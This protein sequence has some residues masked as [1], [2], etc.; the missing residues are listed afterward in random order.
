MT[1]ELVDSAAQVEPP[2]W[3]D[4][5]VTLRR[6]LH[7]HPELRFE[8]TRTASLLADRLQESGFSVSRG[9]AGTGVVATV[10]RGPGPHVVLRADLDALA[11]PD[12]KDVEYASQVAG[13]AHACGHDVHLT[14]MTTAAKR[15]MDAS[16][17]GRLTV[18]LQPAEEIPYGEP[19]GA[20]AVIDTGLLD[21]ASVDALLGVHCWPWLP[22]GTI[23]IDERVAMAAK[24]A[25][26]IEV[27]GVSAHAAT[28]T[29][30]RDALLAACNLVAVL[31]Q[32]LGRRI[33]ASDRAAFNVGTIRGGRGQSVVPDEVEM[34]GTLRTVD[35]D[36]RQRLKDAVAAACRGT[37]EQ[38]GT[39]VELT[40]ANEMPAVL[41]DTSLVDRADRVLRGVDG[42]TVGRTASPPMTTDD[43][44]LLAAQAPGLYLKLGTCFGGEC[45]PLHNSEFDVDE[46]CLLH[47]I[48]AIEALA[49][50]LLR[51]PASTA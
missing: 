48:A 11:I 28:P 27:R 25:F 10:D 8:E 47:G 26:R 15:L 33:E 13:V 14:V 46:R 31:H 43:F 34:T 42:L 6:E 36:V 4:E 41:N 5:A 39:R 22:V 44:A 29:S 9:I 40:W 7:R 49:L 23:G 18:L 51:E 45:P 21:L 1:Q 12:T 3:W 17:R 24:D 20:Q 16:W 30:G 19:S 37:A 32:M 2:G 35:H 50:D 38:S